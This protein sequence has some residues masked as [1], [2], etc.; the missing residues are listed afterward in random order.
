MTTF[1]QGDFIKARVTAQGL[2]SGKMYQVTSLDID[3]KG[4][5]GTFVTYWVREI[6]KTTRPFAIGN[7]HMITDKMEPYRVTV[8]NRDGTPA[9]ATEFQ[10]WFAGTD[11]AKAGL[12]AILEEQ[13]Y[14]V[15]RVDVITEEQGRRATVRLA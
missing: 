12:K 3:N 4:I 1:K 8:L 15:A 14:T 5:F 9:S 10:D 6:G 7:A 2:T 11:D 13:G